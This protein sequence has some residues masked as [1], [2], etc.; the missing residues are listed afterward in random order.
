MIGCLWTRVRKEPIIA[1]YFESETVSR[2]YIAVAVTA[3]TSCSEGSRQANLQQCL[4]D[5][6]ATGNNNAT[7]WFGT[8]YSTTCPNGDD[9]TI[10]CW[11]PDP[12]AQTLFQRIQLGPGFD[13]IVIDRFLKMEF[14]S[15]PGMLL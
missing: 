2:F 8:Q 14:T 3:A 4:Q 6:R 9:G 10:D 1:L 12:A 7:F 13:P 15:P 5:I 11:N